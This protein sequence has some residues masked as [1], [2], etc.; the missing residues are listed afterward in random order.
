MSENYLDINPKISNIKKDNK[1]FI[2]DLK[3]HLFLFHFQKIP[4]KDLNLCFMINTT[5]GV[6][7]C[8]CYLT[9][10]SIDCSIKQ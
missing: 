8:C 9:L 4:I 7:E 2:I 3:S 5:L 6:Y 10:H 1:H